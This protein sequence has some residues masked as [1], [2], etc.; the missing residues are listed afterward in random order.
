MKKRIKDNYLSYINDPLG[1]GA[2]KL[3]LLKYLRQSEACLSILE[4]GPGA[5]DALANAINVS[6]LKRDPDEYSVIDIDR[7]IL[8]NLKKHPIISKYHKINYLHQNIIKSPYQDRFFDIINLS[9]IMHE[10]AAYHGGW[11]AIEQLADSTA[12]L[13]NENGILLLRELECDNFQR[14]AKCELLGTPINIFFR[15]FFRRFLDHKYCHFSK[16]S[17]YDIGSIRLYLH[18]IKYS[19]QEFFSHCQSTPVDNSVVLEAPIGIIKE[20]QRHF[21]TF[22]NVYSPE[23]FY[24]IHETDGPYISLDFKKNNALH[25]FIS[26]CQLTNTNYRCLNNNCVQIKKSDLPLI[27]THIMNKFF[28]LMQSYNIT[29]PKNHI[30]KLKTILG[31]SK[32]LFTESDHGFELSLDSILLLDNLLM[33]LNYQSDVNQNIFDW[34]RREGDEYYY[35]GDWD[36]IIELF[37]KKS[38]HKT[39][40]LSHPLDSYNC[41]VPIETSFV[42]RSQYINI[43]KSF[44]K[45]HGGEH[46]YTELEGKRIVHLQMMPLQVAIPKIIDFFNQ[47]Y[48]K[49][50]E[51]LLKQLY[52]RNSRINNKS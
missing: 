4:V 29:V 8:E 45:E 31:E 37:I 27:E 18:G 21:L 38:I 3:E 48:K 40:N 26:C 49:V 25:G 30:Q 44:F 34:S 13:V 36:E 39:R 24:T 19:L 46:G 35:F 41:L 15:I 28:D 50:D 6:K 32:C 5:G 47:H 23:C 7:S 17:Y 1:G 43:L 33:S 2:D 22:L 10:C 51:D 12:T 9:S 52:D 14:M 11:Q 20:V 16:P 42:P